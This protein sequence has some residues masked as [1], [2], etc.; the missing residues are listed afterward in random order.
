MIQSLISIIFENIECAL[1]NQHLL[2]KT[3]D[4][5]CLYDLGYTSI[6]SLLF[7]LQS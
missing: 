4:A 7:S 2:F 1:E 3:C 6:L 5:C